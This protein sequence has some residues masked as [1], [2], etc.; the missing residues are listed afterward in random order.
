MWAN[1]LRLLAQRFQA[2]RTQLAAGQRGEADPALVLFAVVGA[3]VVVGGITFA[4]VTG[5]QWGSA[6]SATAVDQANEDGARLA[7]L[8]DVGSATRVLPASRTGSTAQTA[9]RF[10]AADFEGDDRCRVVEW[11]LDDAPEDVTVEDNQSGVWVYRSVAFHADADADGQCVG[12]PTGVVVEK[13]VLKN[14]EDGAQF[15]YRNGHMRD[16]VFPVSEEP[17]VEACV[18][19]GKND[20]TALEACVSHSD[21]P[22]PVE[23]TIWEWADPTPAQIILEMRTEQTAT[24]AGYGS[25]VGWREMPGRSELTGVD[26][27]VLMDSLR[28]PPAPAP[29]GKPDV[30]DV[31]Q[32]SDPNDPTRDRLEIRRTDTRL[33]DGFEY[34]C[35]SREAGTSSW[36]SWGSAREFT[37]PNPPGW[38]TV[39]NTTTGR[40]YEC[41]QHGWVHAVT[42]EH[43]NARFL[44]GESEWVSGDVVTRRP[45][46]TTISGQLL[47][48]SNARFTW[49]RVEGATSWELQYRYNDDSWVTQTLSGS[50]TSWTYPSTM[51]IDSQIRARVRAVN[52]GGKAPWVT[53]SWVRRAI[54]APNV[55]LESAA[56][57]KSTYYASWPAVAGFN[58]SRG[59]TYEIQIR[60]DRNSDGSYSTVRNTATRNYNITGVQPGETARIRVRTV[61]QYTTSGWSTSRSVKRPVAPPTGSISVN[62]R[63]DQAGTSSRAETVRSSWSGISCESGASP[64][65]RHRIRA[66]SWADWTGWSTTTSVRGITATEGTEVIVRA[67]ARCVANGSNSPAPDYVQNS[68]ITAYTRTPATPT[69]RGP[70]GTYAPG[71]NVTFSWSSSGAGYYQATNSSYAN[72]YTGTAT[73]QTFRQEA[74]RTCVRARAAYSRAHANA[75]AWSG[76]S[77]STCA[78]LLTAPPAPTFAATPKWWPSN[79]ATPQLAQLEIIINSAARATSYQAQYQTQGVTGSSAWGSLSNISS[80]TNTRAMC[81]GEHVASVQVRARASNSVGTSAWR[82]ATASRQGALSTCR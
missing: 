3:V 54:G 79:S 69:V 61:G 21:T 65:Y 73:S 18:G 58:S 17:G 56:Y 35:R 8:G 49:D 47:S 62:T 26:D 81:A 60:R 29:S 14:V 33:L 46:V 22:K 48:N 70:S 40:E 64:R 45:D 34:R 74:D 78:A 28:N 67:Q 44:E 12:E 53:A 24:G 27:P 31:K 30:R 9:V 68:H 20:E 52:A 1:F 80:G 71:A 6:M 25:Q 57:G 39:P 36:T 72:R 7:W 11:W 4:M 42:G 55:S 41:A 13:P 32:D 19:I 77:G 23:R 15:V 50:A 2:V 16:L 75:G 76:Y 37:T 5:L 10:D 51:P 63:R 38:L 43:K 82:T 59:H 66:G